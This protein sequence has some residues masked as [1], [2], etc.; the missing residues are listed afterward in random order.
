MDTKKIEGLKLRAK[1][2]KGMGLDI[3]SKIGVFESSLHDCIERKSDLSSLSK[4]ETKGLVNL[5]E[6]GNTGYQTAT[7]CMSKNTVIPYLKFG[8]IDVTY[9]YNLVTSL[10]IKNLSEYG[11]LNATV[12]TDLDTKNGSFNI[13]QVTTNISNY[14]DIIIGTATL[15]NDIFDSMYMLESIYRHLNSVKEYTNDRVWN[16]EMSSAYN[17]F[18]IYEDTF[19]KASQFTL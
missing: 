12:T 1:N 4:T 11:L 13:I 14:P 7:A 6:K 16:I 18:D 10:S 19:F 5:Y 8:N 9:F 3:I 2:L 17:I 15:K